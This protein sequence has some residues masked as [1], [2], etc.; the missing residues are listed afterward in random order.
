[1]AAGA[2][3]SGLVFDMAGSYYPVFVVAT[4]IAIFATISMPRIK[5]TSVTEHS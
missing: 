3:F 1:M 4:G 5:E 2:Y